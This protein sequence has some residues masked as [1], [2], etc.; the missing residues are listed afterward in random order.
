MV[1]RSVPI[2]PHVKTFQSCM[3]AF[4]MLVMPERLATNVFVSL[5]KHVIIRV[6]Y[7]LQIK[8]YYFY[9]YTLVKFG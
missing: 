5:I 9:Y 7:Q 3:N 1:L 6:F 2:I 4:A 8:H